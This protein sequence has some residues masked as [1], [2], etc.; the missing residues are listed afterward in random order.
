[1]TLRRRQIRSF[2]HHSV[3][4]LVR[5]SLLC[6]HGP[7]TFLGL[8]RIAKE[9]VLGA[10]TQRRVFSLSRNRV[11]GDDVVLGTTHDL[12]ALGGRGGLLSRSHVFSFSPEFCVARSTRFEFPW[13]VSR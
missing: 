12:R 8:R 6:I 1:M 13:C 9:F 5:G 4:R 7:N 10:G 11:V 3:G 2:G